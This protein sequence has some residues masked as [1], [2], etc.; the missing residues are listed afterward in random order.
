EE[1]YRTGFSQLL[2]YPEFHD[3][4]ALA[5]SLSLFENVRSMRLIL[6]ECAKVN[7]MK[8]WIGDDLAPFTLSTPECSVIAI[9]YCINHKPVGAVGLLGPT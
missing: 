1:I 9:P 2:A 6:R 7:R 5:N 4:N 3:P 8:Y